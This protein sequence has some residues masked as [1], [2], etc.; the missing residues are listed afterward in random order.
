MHIGPGN[1]EFMIMKDP[2]QI[3]AFMSRISPA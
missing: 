3:M 1:V 2:Y